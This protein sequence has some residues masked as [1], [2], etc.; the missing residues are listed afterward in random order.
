V[1]SFLKSRATDIFDPPRV[2]SPTLTESSSI[3]SSDFQSPIATPGPQS[4]PLKELVDELPP[5]PF[6]SSP[7][8]DIQR[9]AR[10]S[11]TYEDLLKSASEKCPLRRQKVRGVPYSGPFGGSK[12][13]HACALY[14]QS[15]S[16]F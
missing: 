2:E 3:L 5:F 16:C 10:R 7:L 1:P 6:V 12:G 9:R 14:L 4:D 15:L 8:S 13:T 11:L